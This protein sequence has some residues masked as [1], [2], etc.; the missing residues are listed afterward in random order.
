MKR[1]SFLMLIGILLVNCAGIKHYYNRDGWSFSMTQESFKNRLVISPKEAVLE[2][3][4]PELPTG[5]RLVGVA[6]VKVLIDPD[7]MLVATAID[8]EITNAKWLDKYLIAAAKKN[9]YAKMKDQLNRPT[10]YVAIIVYSFR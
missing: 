8:R 2:K 4:E 10:H 6:S 1:V 7:G 5:V 9:K 3:V